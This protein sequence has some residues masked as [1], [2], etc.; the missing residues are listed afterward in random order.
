MALM[1][2]MAAAA[3]SLIAA[4]FAVLGFLRAGRAGEPAAGL[5]DIIRTEADRIRSAADEQARGNRQELADTIRGLQDSLV[6]RLDGGVE[7]LQ[8]PVTAIGRKL[9]EDMARMAEEAAHSRDVLRQSIEGKL[10]AA[11]QQSGEAARALREELTG[12][13]DKTSRMLSENMKLFGDTQHLRLAEMKQQV[14]ELSEKQGAA[15][16]ALRQTVEGRLD[17]LRQENSAK[18]DEM[19]Q[20]VDEK[21]QS[22]LDKRLMESFQVVQL[23]LESVHKGLGEM[24]NLAVGVG[25]LKRVLTNVKTRGIVGEVQL[26]MML[27]QFLSPDQFIRNAQVKADSAE[28]VEFAIR[29]FSRDGDGDVLLPIDAKFPH[30]DYDRLA[31]AAD[32]ADPD[33]VEAAA[34]ALEAAVRGFAKTISDKYINPPETTDFAI[35]Y[36]PTEPLFAEIL[37]R[38]GLHEQLQREYRV[39][40]AGP[41]TLACMLNAFQ[42]GFRSLA[43][44]KQ[45]SEVWKIL[46]AVRGEFA[47]HGKV[48]ARLQKQLGAASNTIDALGTRTKAMNRKLRDVETLPAGESQTV[49]GLSAAVLAAEEGID[50]AAE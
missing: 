50:D 48:V 38:P 32:R 18:L 28:R 2:A 25:D 42:M 7:R 31:Q 35:L 1:L 9:D 43:I 41:T 29:F 8:Q 26:G 30:E 44:Q 3:F 17:M 15:G 49:L 4:I 5:A 19:R 21:L 33:A 14:G 16:E 20:T 22:T 47:E 34:R 46:G 37:R 13:F 24:Q 11:T 27:E 45:S 10:D 6:Q 12:N 36:L 23:Q 40:V 39:T